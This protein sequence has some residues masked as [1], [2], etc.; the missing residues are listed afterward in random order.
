MIEQ[1]IPGNPHAEEAAVV[2]AAFDV[3][4][5]KGLSEQE[6]ELRR[7]RFGPNTL[8]S[9]RSRPAW[10]IL[11]DQFVSLMVALLGVAAFISW[12][13][14]DA[15][16]AVAIIAVLVINALV[17]FAMEWQAGRALDALR[18]Q[19][20]M[21]ARVRRDGHEVMLDAE[22][23]VPGDIIILNSGDRIPADARL[24][25]AASLRTE[26]S[27]LTGES[28]TV[29]KTVAPVSENALLAE[30]YSM[31]YLG[32]T[33]ANG[34][35]VALVTATGTE[36]ELGKIGKLVAEAREEKTPL[37]TR[38]AELG[39][40]LIY[41]VLVIALVILIAG[42]VR[43]DDMWQM[44]E[45]AISLAVAAVPEGLPT[46]TTLILALGVLR[47]ARSRAI[48]RR[49]PAVETLGST[50]VI[51]TD[52]TGTLTENRMTVREYKLSNGR[53]FTLE[54]GHNDAVDDRDDLLFRALQVS[55]LCNE[56]AFD[57]V[58]REAVG[59]PTETALLH[60]AHQYGLN[61]QQERERYRKLAEYPF[62]TATK[63]M[64]SVYLTGDN[65][66]SVFLKGAPSTV[67]KICHQQVDQQNKVVSFDEQ[68][69]ESVISVNE[70]MAGRALRVLALAEKKIELK[71]RDEIAEEELSDG[72]TFLGLVGMVD[73]PRSGVRETIQEARRAGIRIVMLTGDQINTA[74]AIAE[75]LQLSGDNPPRTL[76]A[77]ELEGLD[78]ERLTAKAHNTDVFARVSPEDKLHI[79]EALSKAGEV[80]AVTGDG[81][82]DAPA[83]K[84]ADIGI[85]MGLRGTEAAKEAADVVLADDNL[86]TLVKAIE[87]GRTIYANIIK[88]VH[89]MFSE[90]LSEV[91]VIF[92]AM[93]IGWPLPLL[94]L[95]ILWVN[96][97]T[98]V[99][100]ALALAVEPSSPRIMQQRP[101]SPKQALLSR[102]FFI[103]VI[104]QGAMLA[105][106]TLAA[107]WWALKTY[108]EGSHARTVALFALIGVQIG[109]LF[110]CR[111]RS[112]SAFEGI[113][114]NPFIWLSC[115]VS[116]GLQF[117]ALY[118]APL[119]R[120]LG[121][122]PV[123]RQDII[124]CGLAI[125]LPVLMVEVVKYLFSS[126]HSS[127]EV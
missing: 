47:M 57:S 95:Q 64:I 78:A 92:A 63:R 74:R 97:V 123:N 86:A 43:G 51:C 32:T 14:G 87:G 5:L 39:Q 6:V 72:Y 30:R 117:L 8:Q 126:K 38:L 118:F 94:P 104:W 112:R 79:V 45:V 120:V 122:V 58:R 41:V 50:T 121:T 84:R 80:V 98:D 46:V 66:A 65:E 107:Y 109:H 9:V 108:G 60:A 3:E 127:D 115:V 116:I 35:A 23:I 106:I 4:P 34:H 103:L 105:A 81:V 62:D 7:E 36:T 61:I 73:P 16:E 17:G 24:I 77:R 114:Q 76:H 75:E 99:F 91:I 15:I 88:F 52:K 18:R 10:R 27:A 119:A 71:E 54:E 25:E 22:E 82:N 37:E 110:N 40:R 33:V 20:R 85:A 111:S 124:V 1:S 56:A 55:V 2:A 93:L 70:E 12:L 96:L 100:P 125:I 49:L 90:N 21:S 102:Q 83:L 113:W 29:E 44:G 26:E 48:V 19:S 89:L 13:T 42:W 69:R 31:M 28:V 101:R 53:V 11:V 59:D 67:L 68:L